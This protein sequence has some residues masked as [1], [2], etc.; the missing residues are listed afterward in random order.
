ML[1][2]GAKQKFIWIVLRFWKED[3]LVKI[4]KSLKLY[5]VGLETPSESILKHNTD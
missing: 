5:K 3:N 1:K 2:N 4:I